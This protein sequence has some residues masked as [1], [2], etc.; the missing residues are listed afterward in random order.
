MTPELTP[1]EQLSQL[2]GSYK[3]EW[4][5]E[6][7]YDF[8]TEPAYFPELK[9]SRPCMLVGGRGTGKTT[10]LRCLSYEGQFA[11]RGRKVEDISEW[12]YYGMYY[13][14]NTNRVTAFK[15]PELPEQK[16]IGLFAHY[17]NLLL[18]DLLLKFLDWYH[19]HCPDSAQLES[20]ACTKVA[21]S[22]NLTSAND[23]ND[24]ANQIDDLHVK[25]EAYINNVASQ[26]PILLSAQGAPLDILADA[27][28]HLPQ[29][30]GKNFF[31]LLD[32]YEN[33]EDYQQQ[34]VNTLIK[35]AGQYYSFKIGVRELG[36][37]QRTT[38]NINEQLISPAD[39]VKI[40]I[41]EKLTDDMFNEFALAV[42]NTRMSKVS[43]AD[44]S[45]ID[46]S[47]ILPRLSEEQ[48]AQLLG[49]S[50]AVASIKEDLSVTFT[51]EEIE[52][53]DGLSQ[54]EQY[55]LKY[56]ASS[57]DKSITEIYKDFLDNR[58]EWNERFDNY[59]HALLFTLR[60]KKRGI[61][62]YYAGWD[63]F[64]KLAAHN[65]RYLIEL[66]DQS[67]LLHLQNGHTLSQPVGPDI[68]TL[69]AQNTGKKNLSELEGLSVHGAKLT[70]LLLGLGRI[71]QVMAGDPAGHAPEV[72]QFY[73]AEDET[74][75][76]ISGDIPP[77]L[78]A[79]V[80]H[81]ALV[82]FPG[83]KL[84]D[85]GDTRDYDYMIH[86]IY[87]PFFVFSHRKK[88]KMKITPRQLSGLIAKP[89][90]TIRNILAQ[91]NRIFDEDLPDQ[92]RLFEGFYF[93]NT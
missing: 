77:L 5:K 12:P 10:V 90:E 65:V 42:C 38:L 56:W 21:K 40:P 64:V 53:I 87:S 81:L 28:L 84:I 22:F 25:F 70:K 41:V 93:G 13:R 2:F 4:L 30:R 1:Q 31:F 50:S 76:E 60:Q 82:R 48:E 3:A 26:P 78:N 23:A 67:L 46:V 61:R 92:L 69:A 58:K 71:F 7:M 89:K 68:Q 88:R 9:T 37:R 20:T 47:A 86:P 63:T 6:Q 54:L 62:K 24:L 34:I 11:L 66:V 51:D 91:N 57:Q 52:R 85:E 17:L 14:V 18:C 45:T 39:Y 8:F 32:E 83:S 59:K 36:W 16:W 75:G 44:T 35:H 80:M 55:F 49:V 15:G 74:G 19:R 33:F 29:F 79:A 27:V 43:S 72:N 73:L